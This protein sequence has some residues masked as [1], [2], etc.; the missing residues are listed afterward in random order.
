MDPLTLLLT[1]ASLAIGA[2]GSWYTYLAYRRSNSPAP[3]IGRRVSVTRNKGP[4]LDAGETLLFLLLIDQFPVGLWGAS[5]EESAALYGHKGDPGSITIS[6]I[7]S[8]AISAATGSRTAQPI[9]LYRNYLL[10]RRSSR[11]A[12]GMRR[13]PGTAKYP[14]EEI[15]EHA[16]HTATAL[17]FFLYYDGPQHFCV[18]EALRYLLDEQ[19]RTKGGLWVDHGE[20]VETNVD[21]VTVAFVVGALE[22]MRSAIVSDTSDPHIVGLDTLDAA[23]RTGVEYVF[24]TRL[25]TPE[26]LWLYRY[27][28]TEE[29]SRVVKNAYQYTTD[30]LSNIGR[31][32]RR[33]NL[34]LAEV[35][36]VFDGLVRVGQRYDGGLPRSPASN[37]PD[38]DTT[39]TT[40]TIASLLGRPE[41]VQRALYANAIRLCSDRLAM[42]NSAA[43]GWSALLSL[44]GLPWTVEL[45]LAAE[46][47]ERVYHAARAAV[48]ASAE[49]SPIPPLV[50]IPEGM[51]RDLLARRRGVQPS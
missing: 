2:I 3:A 19:T 33:L 34:H 4:R 9:Q 14:K 40:V 6:T 32:C 24:N 20:P 25:R 11:G 48:V 31:T 10:T 5:L 38:L 28:S 45:Q 43:N 18:V 21:P 15:L 47:T 39:A 17:R 8:K 7:S 29:E 46:V 23:I 13:A 27:R 51:V 30:V 42:E 12:F 50:G 37:T 41:S 16:R 36:R 49:A 35:D 1:V 26:G 44:A 22:D